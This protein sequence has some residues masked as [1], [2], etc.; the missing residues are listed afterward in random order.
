MSVCWTDKACA[1][2][3]AATPGAAD[4]L[5]MEP[6]GP[7][8]P[9]PGLVTHALV[10]GA[11][12]ATAAACATILRPRRRKQADRAVDTVPAPD[13]P[14]V[15]LDAPRFYACLLSVIRRHLESRG[16]RATNAMTPRELAAAAPEPER[17]ALPALCLRAEQAVYG[18]HAISADQR[19]ED[20]RRIEALVG[21][22]GTAAGGDA[23]GV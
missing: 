17:D 16:V 2:L 1:L 4:S 21:G 19:R 10:L 13:L 5:L 22:R 3:L 6:L 23:D 9:P 20:L 11:C 14:A 12:L 15:D 7:V 18:G 8:P